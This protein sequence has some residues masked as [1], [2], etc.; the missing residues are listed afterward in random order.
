MTLAPIGLVTSGTLAQTAVLAPVPDCRQAVCNNAQTKIHCPAA[1][2]A[3]S[4]LDAR[5]DTVQSSDT[6]DGGGEINLAFNS[7]AFT[8]KASEQD[9]LANWSSPPHANRMETGRSALQ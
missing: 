7:I 1:G 6:D 8:T 5:T 2:A 3:F 4:R 9:C